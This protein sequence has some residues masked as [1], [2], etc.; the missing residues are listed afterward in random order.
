MTSDKNRRRA[1]DNAVDTVCYAQ[2]GV[3]GGNPEE[4]AAQV[5][6]IAEQY[7]AWLEKKPEIAVPKR[8]ELA[9][10]PEIWL[11]LKRTGRV[12]SGGFRYFYREHTNDLYRV[13]VPENHQT[14]TEYYDRQTQ[15]WHLT[16]PLSH[17]ET[18]GALLRDPGTREL[19]A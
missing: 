16:S 14:R 2:A 17:R 5:L 15:G 9:L 8:I 11:K 1:L 18:L 19:F 7:L 3:V 10:E 13:K 6:K 12:A 4:D